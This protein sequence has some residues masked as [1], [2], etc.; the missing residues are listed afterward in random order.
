M[1]FRRQIIGT[2][3]QGPKRACGCAPAYMMFASRG[4]QSHWQ[5]SRKTMARIWSPICV[6]TGKRSVT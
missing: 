6:V 2:A 3:E 1:S 4:P 5:R